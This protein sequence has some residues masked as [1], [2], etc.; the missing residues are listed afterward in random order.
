MPSDAPLVE[1]DA[2][3]A[4]D[5]PV[6]GQRECDLDEVPDETGERSTHAARLAEAQAQLQTR[7]SFE[8][9]ITGLAS[10]LINLSTDEIA[11]GLRD[12]L[13]A[14]CSFTAFDRGLVISFSE[15]AEQVSVIAE[16]GPSLPPVADRFTDLPDAVLSPWLRCLAGRGGGYVSGVGEQASCPPHLYDLG[17]RAG[18]EAMYQMPL[19]CGERLLGALILGKVSG[20]VAWTEDTAGLVQLCTEMFANS[21]DRMEKGRALRMRT[22]EIFAILDGTD[23]GLLVSDAQ[24]R[25]VLASRRFRELWGLSSLPERGASLERVVGEVRERLADPSQVPR[26]EETSAEAV[27]R[28]TVQLVLIDGRILEWT[29]YAL[30]LP[31]SNL[32]TAWSF[33]DVTD[34]AELESQLRQ[35][36]KLEAVGQLAGGIAHDFNNVLFTISSACELALLREPESS[37]AQTFKQV[38]ASAQRAAALTRQLLAFSRKQVL[39]FRRVDVNRV[40]GDVSEMLKRLLGGSAELRLRLGESVGP[41]RADRVQLEQVLLN[42]VVNARDAMPKGGVVTIRTAEVMVGR[43][44]AQQMPG[45]R[46]GPHVVLAVADE[47]EGMSDELRDRIFEPFFTTKEVGKGTGLGLATVFGIV[48]QHEGAVQVDTVVGMGTEMRVYLPRLDICASEA[49]PPGEPCLAPGKGETILLVEDEEAARRLTA[50]AL[51]RAGFRVIP[52]CNGEEAMH[53]ALSPGARFDLLL[54]DFILPHVNGAEL[55]RS[56]RERF[57]GLPVVYMSG[58]AQDTLF[59]RS[60]GEAPPFLQKPFKLVE[61]TR[62][63]RRVLDDARHEEPTTKKV[64]ALG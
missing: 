25:V 41:V 51:A 54:T 59:E 7:L 13:A 56:M 23:D 44:E 21:L 9:M 15:E 16:W 27:S 39:S 63:V 29:R 33:R 38:L 5:D 47:G 55:A 19:A 43:A 40:V 32:G 42:L 57:P 61:L 34:R 6:V 26:S 28:R 48:K 14:L 62:L 46:A 4:G 30:L 58:H 49:V 12:A 37:Q 1:P 22:A 50:D 17:R 8:L 24:G 11:P 52:A 64:E 36:Q 3:H 10:R 45:L 20:D 2:G 31:G 60:E 18:V 35:A 53:K